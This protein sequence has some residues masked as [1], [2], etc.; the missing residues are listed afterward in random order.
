MFWNKPCHYCGEEIVGIGIDR[1][2]NKIGYQVDNIV[3]CCAW[4]NKMKL[5]AT[6]ED[7]INHCKKIVEFN[8]L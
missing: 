4:C 8:N 7:F 2:N 1:V 3:P 5:V 6:K